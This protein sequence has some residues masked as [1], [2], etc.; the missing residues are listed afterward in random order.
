MKKYILLAILLIPEIAMPTTLSAVQIEKLNLNRSLGSKIFI[1]T[2][3]SPQEQTR[4]ECHTDNNW[5]FVLPLESDLDKS[6]YS[7]LLAALASGKTVTLTGTNGCDESSG[8]S[9]I[10]TLKNF[11]IHQ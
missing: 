4:I 7:S 1:R 9:T 11:T 8:Y 3:A 5:N 6:I 10:E 2:S